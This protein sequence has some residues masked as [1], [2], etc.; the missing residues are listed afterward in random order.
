MALFT[1]DQ[2][3]TG[4]PEERKRPTFKDCAKVDIDLTFFNNDEHARELLVDGKKATVIFEEDSLRRHTAH[5]EA[6]AK[7]NFDTGLY[8]AYSVLYIPV[9]IYGP[10]PKIGNLIELR[11]PV[12]KWRRTFSIRQCEDEE[13]VYR[14]ILERT[15]Q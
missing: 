1:L 2:D 8:T 13:G 10:K 12:E 4:K 9:A 11:E 15:R 7:Q 5:W 6:G 3:Y 14:M